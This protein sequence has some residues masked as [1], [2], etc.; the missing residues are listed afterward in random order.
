MI[1]KVF[2]VELMRFVFRVE[3]KD[4]FNKNNN[5]RKAGVAWYY[6]AK[7]AASVDFSEFELAENFVKKLNEALTCF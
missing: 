6:L 1:K 2:H 7:D 5:S 4:F 3:K